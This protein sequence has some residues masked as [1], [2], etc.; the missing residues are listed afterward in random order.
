MR[1]GLIDS[2]AEAGSD[3]EVLGLGRSGSGQAGGQRAG[4]VVWW[5]PSDVPHSH[6]GSLAS[7][8]P[9]TAYRCR[10]TGMQ[11]ILDKLLKRGGWGFPSAGISSAR[12]G[13]R[14]PV[15]RRLAWA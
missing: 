4:Q 13:G 15:P 2:V 6:W 14:S 11:Y 9:H 7:M 5:L 10:T 3:V 12:T 1:G 8:L